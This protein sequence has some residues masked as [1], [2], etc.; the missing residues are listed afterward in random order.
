MGYYESVFILQ[1]DLEEE[2]ITRRV[3][4]AEQIVTGGGGEL[5]NSERWGKKR[6]A[7]EI[8]RNRYGYY[9]LLRYR[10]ESAVLKE[11]ERHLK[12]T[13]AVLKYMTVRVRAGITTPAELHAE[14]VRE[15]PESERGGAEG[16]HQPPAKL[17]KDPQE[18]SEKDPQEKSAESAQ[19]VEPHRESEKE[20]E[21]ESSP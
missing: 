6:L 3:E 8:K 18:K 21:A 20:A 5:S 17:E 4:A 14:P 12:I 15:R 16:V 11:L 2:E 9:V 7:Y 13:E 10:A 19:L 1:P